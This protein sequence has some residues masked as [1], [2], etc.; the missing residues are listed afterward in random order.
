MKPIFFT[1]A[2]WLGLAVLAAIIA[3]YL[4]ISIALVEICVGIAA[5]AIADGFFGQ[6][7]L[8]NGEQWLQFLASAGAILLTFLAGAELDPGIM[9]R[10]M[11]EVSLVGIV[12]FAAPFIGATAA[13]HF[14]LG[15]SFSSSLLA[16]IALS[17]TSMAVV[18]AVMVETG[19]TFGTISA[20]FGLSH[21][22]LTEGQYSGLV[23]TVIASALVPTFIATKWFLP[24]K[25]VS[26]GHVPPKALR[27]SEGGLADE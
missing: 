6:G 11:K 4:D 17:T 7:S 12:G 26:A 27:V 5:G 24:A 13:A 20:M 10:K 15:W 3:H 21:G 23:A 14:I 9:K 18:Y 16:G 25:L 22:I 2:L 1:A 8:G 19:L